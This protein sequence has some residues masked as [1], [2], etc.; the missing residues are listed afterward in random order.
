MK[1]I[2]VTA[3]LVAA[4]HSEPAPE[5][6]PWYGWGWGW[7]H[8]G[9]GYGY[10]KRSADAEPAPNADAKAEPWYYGGYG[11]PHYGGYW[12]GKRSA[13]AEP[14]PN[15]DAKA[16]PWYGWGYGWPPS[17]YN[18]HPNVV[19]W[20]NCYASVESAEEVSRGGRKYFSGCY[21]KLQ[22]SLER[23]KVLCEVTNVSVSALVLMDIIL[24]F[25][26]ALVMRSGGGASDIG[27]SHHLTY[28]REPQPPAT[29][30]SVM[31]PV[32]AVCGSMPPCPRP[33][34]TNCIPIRPC[35]R[36]RSWYPHKPE[37][38]SF[39]PAIKW[40]HGSIKF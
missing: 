26:M 13:D 23:Y 38:S 3:L 32:P 20:N 7:P 36:P 14:A 11:W 9:Y 24:L 6:K 12:Y 16:E 10:G 35:H 34:S 29:T 39:Q 31:S 17:D 22:Q 30:T 15:A 5:A 18:S 40:F 2:L 37:Q 33:G 28:Y 1:L 19:T 21:T 4:A 25:F 8:Y 27:S